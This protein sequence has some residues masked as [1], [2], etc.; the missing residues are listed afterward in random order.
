M[1]DW[2]QRWN[3]YRRQRAIKKE[4]SGLLSLSR[5]IEHYRSDL[6]SPEDLKT[7]QK[8]RENFIQLQKTRPLEEQDLLA[9]EEFLR[10]H[11]GKIYP[12]HTLR[13]NCE[14]FLMAIIVAL[15]V[16]TFF[17]QPFQI[18]TNSMWPSFYGMTTELLSESNPPLSPWKRIFY[19][20]TVYRAKTEKG[21]ILYIPINTHAQAYQQQSLISY[22]TVRGFKY[23]F[24]PVKM[25]RY[26]LRVGTELV[27]IEV[28]F[29]LDLEK[30]FL[31]SYFP[32]YSS[33][34][35][36][37]ILAEQSL[38]SMGGRLYLNTHQTFEPQSDVLKFVVYSGDALLVDRCSIHFFEP[39]RGGAYVFATR[40]VPS[41]KD[42][43]RYYIKRLV[44]RGGDEVGVLDQALWVNG[45]PS[46]TAKAIIAN[47]E[48]Q[49]PYRGYATL[50]AFS[51]GPVVVPEK[52]YYML[53]DNSYNSYDSRF[54]GA[55]PN[56]AI[57]GRPF[58][59]LFPFF[60]K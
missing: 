12:I 30:V 43:D 31:E 6:M 51:E 26:E 59:V 8:R 9:F 49:F 28:P 57:K 56:R 58:L 18:P 50:G 20:Q 34:K 47:N 35:L 1:G 21:G 53:G 37:D 16:R 52:S 17:V 14:I 48:Q 10:E 54:F 19:G 4:I 36:I 25:R 38:I 5:K 46:D 33:K 39:K 29:E 23:G 3:R 15:G 13:E 11:G 44:A 22:K 40:D 24:W 27:P 55:V 45:E 7:F 41:L 42:S 32:Q 2:K 60:R